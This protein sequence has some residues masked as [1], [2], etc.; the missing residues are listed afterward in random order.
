MNGE[1]LN[2]Q[3]SRYH[4]FTGRENERMHFKRWLTNTDAPFRL[5]YI[6]GIGG[7]GKSSLLMEMAWMA[8]NDRARVISLD[9]GACPK[10]PTGFIDYLSAAFQLAFIGTLDYSNPMIGHV[11]CHGR[12]SNP[13]NR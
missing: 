3:M 2:N 12:S 1:G 4:Y 13:S 11:P 8:R 6:S 7:I 5:F 9:G 10:T